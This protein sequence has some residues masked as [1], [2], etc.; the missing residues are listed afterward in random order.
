MV[1]GASLESARQ[2]KGYSQK[3]REHQSG[4]GILYKGKGRS[5]EQN[6]ILKKMK[7]F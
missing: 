5:G 3:P 6:W 2:W 7:T 4:G 1:T